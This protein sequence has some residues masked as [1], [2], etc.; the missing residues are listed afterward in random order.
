[1][2]NNLKHTSDKAVS[3]LIE[4]SVLLLNHGD[5]LCGVN[6]WVDTRNTDVSYW[7]LYP[8][9]TGL[10]LGTC[11]ILSRFALEITQVTNN[12]HHNFI[13]TRRKPYL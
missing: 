2:R 10:F 6:I 9:L 11:Y 5:K 4:H 12:H 8:S 3:S 7:L 13:E 1:M